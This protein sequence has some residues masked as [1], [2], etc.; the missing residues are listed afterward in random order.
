[1]QGI[2]MQALN[3]KSGK[4]GNAAI[5]DVGH[6][7]KQRKEPSLVIQIGLLDL[8]PVDPVLLHAGLVASHP[9]NHDELLVMRKAPDCPR[10][11]GQA[12]E[13]GDAPNGA[14]GTDDDELVAPRGQHSLDLTNAVSCVPNHGALTKC[15]F[16]HKQHSSEE[17]FP[18]LVE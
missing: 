1:M 2:K 9:R 6:K 16:R 7:A 13:E 3:D 5:R 4:V 8:L 14:T 15:L 18:I 12:D 17:H 10:R 11:V